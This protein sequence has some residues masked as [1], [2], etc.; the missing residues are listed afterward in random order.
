MQLK[1]TN[2]QVLLQVRRLPAGTVTS[3]LEYRQ[4]L[5]HDTYQKEA[6]EIATWLRGDQIDPRT[7]E[8]S[9]QVS[10]SSGKA[11]GSAG[12]Y[13]SG[14]KSPLSGSSKT[15]FCRNNGT[16]ELL[17]VDNFFLLVVLGLFLVL[18]SCVKF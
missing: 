5:P 12:M 15:A 9:D 17:P 7:F 1:R 4:V 18:W 16:P 3:I 8:L 6:C 2:K 14:M 11:S 13:R 10:S